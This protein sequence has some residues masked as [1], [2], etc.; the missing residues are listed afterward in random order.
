L[1]SSLSS[2]L[3]SDLFPHQEQ[4]NQ[5]TTGL[6]PPTTRRARTRLNQRMAWHF[7]Q[8]FPF[9][10][11]CV[12]Q[13]S[14]LHQEQSR[15]ANE[16]AIINNKSKRKGL[17]CCLQWRLCHP[18]LCVDQTQQEMATNNFQQCYNKGRQKIMV[19]VLVVTYYLSLSFITSA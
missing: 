15:K 11:C 17:R 1:A 3:C 13:P 7:G 16:Q 10:C 19:L 2:W 18:S 14:P 4:H 5:P 6:P 9:I 8:H 12:C